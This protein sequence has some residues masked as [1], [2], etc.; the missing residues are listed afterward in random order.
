MNQTSILNIVDTSH[1]DLIHDASLDYYGVKLA[2]CSSDRSVK[3]F[4]VSK[5]LMIDDLRK[6]EGPV[7]QVAWS[8]PMFGNYLASCSYDKK[9]IIWK[10]TANNKWIPFYE[11]AGHE[12][13]VN[14]VSWAPSEYGLAFVCGSSDGSISIVTLSGDA[15]WQPRKIEDAHPTGC[16]SVSWAPVFPQDENMSANVSNTSSGLSAK[17]IVSGGCDNLVKIWRED[18]NG[19]WVLDQ[20]LNGHNDW[21]RDVAW[22]PNVIHSKTSIASCSQGGKVII[23]SCDLNDTGNS[24]LSMWKQT[25]LHEFNNIAWHVSWSLTSNML[26]VSSGDN[27]VTIWKEDHYGKYICINDSTSSNPNSSAK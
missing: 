23:W 19:Q 17:R 7:W 16:N 11:Y 1:E 14:S 10:E 9:V 12:S 15:S 3:I 18:L 27:K 20:Q 13:S 8:H 6:H 2:T 25:T 5:Q 24:A 21:V 26:A 4:D 22:S